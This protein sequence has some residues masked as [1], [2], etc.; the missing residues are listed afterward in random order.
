MDKKDHMADWGWGKGGGGGVSHSPDAF[1]ILDAIKSLKVAL[2]L[3]VLQPG[4]PGD[5][6]GQQV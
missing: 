4:R 2:N 5:L 1:P 3:L 6:S